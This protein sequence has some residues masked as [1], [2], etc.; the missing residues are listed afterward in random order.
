MSKPA[1]HETH[2]Q[3]LKRLKRAEGQVRSVIT[4]IESARPCLDIA[5]QLQAVESAIRAAKKTL[6]HD[7]IDH[8]LGQAADG[9]AARASIEEFKTVTKYL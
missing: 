7:H 2:P 3:I 8:C 4:M 1:L 9:R 5:Q 6:I